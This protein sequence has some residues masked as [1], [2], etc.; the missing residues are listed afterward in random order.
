MARKFVGWI[1]SASDAQLIKSTFLDSYRCDVEVARANVPPRFLFGSRGTKE[2]F[3]VCNGASFEEGLYRLHTIDQVSSWTD[4][5]C[6]AFPKFSGQ[7]EC[8]SFDWLGRMFALD[9]RRAID[10]QPGVLMLEPGTGQ[11]LEIPANFLSFHCEELIQH[12]DAALAQVAYTGWRRKHSKPLQH[13]E[14]AG[15]KVPLFLGGTDT[16]DNMERTDMAVYWELCTQMLQQTQ[17]LPHGTPVK[18]VF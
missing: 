2:L 4:V 13:A 9:S 17:S 5:A 6:A 11:A 8:F 18:G 15:Y 1:L 16:V 10:G 3:A 12:A 7:I 14:C